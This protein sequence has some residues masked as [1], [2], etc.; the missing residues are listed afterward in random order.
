MDQLNLLQPNSEHSLMSD[1]ECCASFLPFC[2]GLDIKDIL[3]RTF[4]KI[5]HLGIGL[6]NA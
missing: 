5:I 1:F 6:I 3:I 2:L 4:F